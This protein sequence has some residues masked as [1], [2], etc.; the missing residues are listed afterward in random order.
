LLLLG[1]VWKGK[2]IAFLLFSYPV[3]NPV[4]WAIVSSPS[5]GSEENW[6]CRCC[7]SKE[8]VGYAALRPLVE[9]HHK[10]LLWVL[11]CWFTRTLSVNLI[12]PIQQLGT[13]Y[14][15]QS[16]IF[17]VIEANIQC[18]SNATFSLPTRG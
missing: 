7:W 3:N 15:S 16:E 6:W 11:V 13:D 12:D 4:V 1:Y 8:R 2:P 10:L 17:W 18:R 9:Q 5:V 14:L